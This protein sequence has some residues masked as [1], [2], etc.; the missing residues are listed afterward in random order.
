MRTENGIERVLKG[1]GLQCV[2]EARHAA[3]RLPGLLRVIRRL[4][5]RP[6]SSFFSAGPTTSGLPA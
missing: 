3:A 6:L 2:V 5:D 4:R 1:S